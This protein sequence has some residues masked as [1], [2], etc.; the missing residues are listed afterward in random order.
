MCTT[1][2]SLI[3]MLLARAEVIEWQEQII[4]ELFWLIIMITRWPISW[5]VCHWCHFTM[6]AFEYQTWR[7]NLLF[8]SVYLFFYH[9]Q[10][11]PEKQSL[12]QQFIVWIQE[13]F[14]EYLKIV[15]TFNGNPIWAQI[16]KRWRRDVWRSHDGIEKENRVSLLDRLMG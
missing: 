10:F 7:R 1:L 14:S 13:Y 9:W 12:K 4:P 6:P 16:S 8:I 5:F 2:V 3:V 15:F 11:D